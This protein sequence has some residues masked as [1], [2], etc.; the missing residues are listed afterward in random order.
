MTEV[1]G[2]VASGVSVALLVV[3]IASS[4]LKLKSYLEQAR[5]APDDIRSVVDE[6][7]E[8]QFL[9]ADMERD[10]AHCREFWFMLERKERAM[11]GMWID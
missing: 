4:V 10:Q 11:P 1:L 9:L 3:Q 6:I 7:E 5:Y 2:V 8:L